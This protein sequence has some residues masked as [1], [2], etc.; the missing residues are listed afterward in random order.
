[1]AHKY[2][3]N[4]SLLLNILDRVSVTNLQDIFFK[5]LISSLFKKLMDLPSLL[6]MENPY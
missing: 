3:N 1:M 4:D 6:M 5:S 2:T